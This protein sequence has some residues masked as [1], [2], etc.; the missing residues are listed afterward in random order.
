[1]EIS[2]SRKEKKMKRAILG[3]I[4]LALNFSTSKTFAGNGND[5]VTLVG[6]LDPKFSVELNADEL[7]DLADSVKNFDQLDHQDIDINSLFAKGDEEAIAKARHAIAKIFIDSA[8]DLVDMKALVYKLAALLKIPN[9]ERFK[10]ELY[11]AYQVRFQG[12]YIS[13]IARLGHNNAEILAALGQC[14][15]EICVTTIAGAQRE[16]VDFGHRLNRGIQFKTLDQTKVEWNFNDPMLKATLESTMDAFLPPN[17]PTNLYGA[18]VLAALTPF[19][20]A[21]RG[22]ANVGTSIF[23]FIANPTLTRLTIH[24]DRI[25]LTGSDREKNELSEIVSGKLQMIVNT[26]ENRK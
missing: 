9:T 1:M 16:L 21:A 23:G 24:A 11:R 3:L 20:A 19:V 12:A 4:F 15:S 26:P 22:T 5:L 18:I 13:F 10:T 25:R 14:H 6:D 8:S 7:R 2:S 17:R